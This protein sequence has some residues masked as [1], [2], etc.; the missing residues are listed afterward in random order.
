MPFF[1][2]KPRAPLNEFVEMLWFCE[3]PEGLPHA[4]ERLLPT[5]TVELVINLK[6]D[7]TR[8]YDKHDIA[9]FDTMAGSVVCGIHT[10]FFVI[11]TAEQQ[12]VMGVHFKPGGAFP[13]LNLPADELRNS[14]VAL[15]DL[16]GGSAANEL[17]ERLLSAA[18]LNERFQILE[19]ALF[20]IAFK[21]LLQHGAVGYALENFTRAP[22]LQKMS[23][24]TDKIGISQR[25]F[26]EV[27]KQKVG[28]TPKAFCRVMR[29]QQAVQKIG[30][31]AEI[32]WL[33]VALDCGYFDQA[34]FVH[35]FRSFA[36][37]TPTEFA[38]KKTEHLNHVP[39]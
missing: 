25:R 35:D 33:D 24:V 20:R 15:N 37:M 21:P 10:E 28:V 11:D 30:S 4:R 13:F 31:G 38:A 18:S 8:T 23:S 16:W 14:H 36:G 22:G 29:F 6:E 9:Q 32:E 26:I 17:R 3:E 27:F 1:H 5:G 34:H 12:L 19:D 39:I 7:A 2:R